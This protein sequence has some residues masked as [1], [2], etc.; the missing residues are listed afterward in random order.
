V[1]FA[2]KTQ[3]VGTAWSNLV[4]VW[5][6]V[7][8]NPVFESAWLFDHL[9]WQDAANTS[10]PCFEAWTALSAL[11]M[12][13]TRV[14]IGVMVSALPYRHPAVLA[15]S[16]A[17]VDTISGGRLELGL[18]AGWNEL[19]T[20]MYGIRLGRT[21]ERLDRFE[22]GV[23][24]VIRLLRDDVT[25]IDGRHV[26]MTAARRDPKGLQRPHPPITIG[27]G[28]ERR[29]LRVAAQY[30]DHWNLSK[31]DA[32]TFSRKREVLRSH[33]RRIGRDE[34]SITHSVQRRLA[35]RA[36]LARW[37]DETHEL[38]ELGV[39]LTVIMLDPPTSP[40]LVTKVAD[41]VARLRPAPC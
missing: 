22:E 35:E 5:R 13:T 8:R 10:Q 41:A 33:C 21:R 23:E 3:Q 39:D 15:A 34:R 17:T 24:A 29:T 4:D 7:D 11:A 32:A 12:V 31:W 2:V 6:E 30:A 20:S 18:G 19:E 16:A 25:N 40:R 36:D 38:S 1:R 27:G 9:Y 28:G 37:M 14:R 26:T